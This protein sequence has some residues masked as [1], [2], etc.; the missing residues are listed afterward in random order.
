MPLQEQADLWMALRDR[1]R[2]SWTDLTLQEKKA[3]YWIAF[4][5]H[6]PRSVD[7]PGTNARIAWGV[8]IGVT[9]SLAL[10]A[11]I[12]SAA[13]PAPYTMTKE[14]QEASNELLKQQNADPFTGIS[15][16]NYTGKGVI[17]SASK[18]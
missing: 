8:A 12:R 10:F 13:K 9:A 1:M 6:G 15:S 11:G 3:A 14:Y 5:P 17:Q 4:G 7:P 16:D 18:H 2:G